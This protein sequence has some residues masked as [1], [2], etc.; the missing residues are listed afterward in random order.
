M[1]TNARFTRR[2]IALRFVTE[3]KSAMVAQQSHHWTRSGVDEYEFFIRVHPSKSVPTRV[4]MNGSSYHLM[5]ANPIRVNPH[6][7]TP[8]ALP[9]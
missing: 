6:P 5:N 3:R 2:Q 4:Q 1:F 8:F 7:F 9:N